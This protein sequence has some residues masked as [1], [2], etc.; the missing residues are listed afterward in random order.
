MSKAARDRDSSIE[1]LLARTLEARASAPTDA[2][3]DAETVAAYADGALAA[4]E[5]TAVEAHAADC[6][7][8]QALLAA[9]AT[10]APPSAPPAP[11]RRLALG[12]LIPLAAAAAAMAI[13]VAVPN[14]TPVV[15]ERPEP[16]AQIAETKPS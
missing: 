4:G 14:Q 3:L 7:R 1:R 5:R 11:A 10:T 2:C 15:R 6:A 16:S 12:W 13:W 9:M 8:C